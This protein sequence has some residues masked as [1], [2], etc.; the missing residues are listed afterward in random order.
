MGGEIELFLLVQHIHHILVCILMTCAKI[1]KGI[2]VIQE[3]LALR[4][5]GFITKQDGVF[6]RLSHIG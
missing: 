1:Y 5:L 2:K 4:W 6:Y 3:L